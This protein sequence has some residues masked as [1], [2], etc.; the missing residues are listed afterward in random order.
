[1][2]F[3]KHAVGYPEGDQVLLGWWRCSTD[4]TEP[5]LPQGPPFPLLQQ[6]LHPPPARLRSALLERA[7]PC[8]RGPLSPPHAALPSSALSILCPTLCCALRPRRSKQKA[9]L[10]LGVGG[11]R[12]RGRRHRQQPGPRLQAAQALRD[13][14]VVCD[15]PEGA[16]PLWQPH[17]VEP[18]QGSRVGPAHS[19]MTVGGKQ[20]TPTRE[21]VGSKTQPP[22]WVWTSAR[23]VES[24]THA[25]GR[26][27]AEV[28]LRVLRAK[29]RAVVS[30]ADQLLA[31]GRQ[32]GRVSRPDV[33]GVCPQLLALSAGCRHWLHIGSPGQRAQSSLE[34]RPP[35][36]APLGAGPLPCRRVLLIRSPASC[37]GDLHKTNS[38]LSGR[39]QCK[40]R[41]LQPEFRQSG[42]PAEIL[43]PAM[44]PQSFLSCTL[45]AFT[46]C[47]LD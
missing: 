7:G 5:S 21:P 17:D 29:H 18:A 41:E 11:H 22:P 20:A 34:S 47:T 28:E 16:P 3:D 33:R 10:L 8:Q 38:L 32:A 12:P 1:M 31:A 9:H 39:T 46:A 37:S 19:P 6:Q 30:W 24:R 14:R 23:A 13:A 35:P 40:G 2:E 44:L 25:P 4:E 36:A 43:L 42:A 15:A 45:P 26:A 27:I